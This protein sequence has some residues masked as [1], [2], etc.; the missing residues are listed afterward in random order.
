MY[1]GSSIVYSTAST[2]PVA[3]PVINN[4]SHHNGNHNGNHIDS[5]KKEIE[6]ENTHKLQRELFRKKSSRIETPPPA[7]ETTINMG[8][9]NTSNKTE[10]FNTRE[11][12]WIL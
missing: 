4:H 9:S 1:L 2:V 12:N 7:F 5:H 3:T 8:N 6:L 11:Y 10:D